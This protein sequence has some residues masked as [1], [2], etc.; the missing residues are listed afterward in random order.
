M[1]D[2]DILE[3]NPGLAGLIADLHS[4]FLTSTGSS[5]SSSQDLAQAQYNLKHKKEYLETKCIF[6]PIERLRFLSLDN[7]RRHQHLYRHHSND[8][9]TATR[10]ANLQR[11]VSTHI[12]SIL[13]I[14]DARR[15]T[16]ETSASTLASASS[17]L[18][19][20]DSSQSMSQEANQTGGTVISMM[21]ILCPGHGKIKDLDG[22]T[23]E[24]LQPHLEALEGFSQPMIRT[25]EQS[26]EDRA[27]DVIALHYNTTDNN[28]CNSGN[29]DPSSEV[30]KTLALKEIVSDTKGRVD[31]LDRGKD[32]VAL[33]GLVIQ[34]KAKTLFDTLQKI[35]VT[36]WEIIVEFKIRHQLEQDMT[37]QEY[38]SSLAGSIV[39]KLDDA[40]E[41]K[42]R[43]LQ[44]QTTQ[45]A[46]LLRQYQSAGQEFNLIVDT[47]ADIMQRIEIVEDDIR[48]LE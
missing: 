28:N 9:L 42:E 38:F 17:G 46:D 3:R 27:E 15:L 12:D 20:N 4:R 32:E 19:N 36:L 45:N 35:I 39:L 43:S 44:L 34:Q 25:I 26:I 11:Q 21:E 37:F 31:A 22:F 8:S 33:R 18:P 48:R 47:Y 16:I 30:P 41:S 10:H 5:L 6:E 13:S 2:P 1:Q 7:H 29:N 14:L 24:Y 40:L 23:L